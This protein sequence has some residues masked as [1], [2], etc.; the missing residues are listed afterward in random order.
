MIKNPNIEVIEDYI[1]ARTKIKH[2]CLI[3]C[4]C[5]NVTPHNILNGRGCPLC[6]NKKNGDR[7]R[8]THEQYVLEL[9]IK[10]PEIEAIEKYINSNIKILHRY[11]EC[12]HE[13]MIAPSS[14]LQGFG[15][16]KCNRNSVG[17]RLKLSQ[18][19]YEILVKQDNP[20][21]KILGKYISAKNPILCECLICGYTWTPLAGALHGKNI[22][23]CPK[24]A[25]KLIGDKL[26]KTLSQYIDELSVI[27]PYIKVIDKTYIDSLTPLKHQCLTC[28]YIWKI[29][30]CNTLKG[31]GCPTCSISHLERDVKLYLD[32]HNIMYSYSAK[33]DNL[34]GIGGR[35]L[36]YDFYLPKY[37][38]VIEC[39]GTQ[40]ERPIEYFGGI[41]KFIIQK[42][43]DTRKRKYAHDYNVNLL[44]I[45]YYEST[46]IDKILEQTL[47]NLN[48]ECVETVIPV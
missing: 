23:G 9:S 17:D 11:K 31:I 8:K 26:R 29:R 38:L 3:C 30:P 46:K 13:A 47:N 25:N 34:L 4:Y 44:E 33:F 43:H 41:K 28:N 14:A 5:W 27:N 22:H 37:N 32:K 12:G 7:L 42:I 1:N 21:V 36:S 10:N 20:N 2:R 40:H 18:S 45:W 16:D 15:C 39:Q 6:R 48:K 19:S 35:Q 24:C